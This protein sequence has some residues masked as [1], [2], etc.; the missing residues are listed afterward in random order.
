MNELD[1]KRW[2]SVKIHSTLVV[3]ECAAE[4]IQPIAKSRKLLYYTLIHLQYPFSLQ[5]MFLS[6]HFFLSRNDYMLTIR[7]IIP[8][9]FLSRL[10]SQIN[11]LLGDRPPK[12]TVTIHSFYSYSEFRSDC[13]DF[14][15]KN[16]QSWFKLTV[17]CPLK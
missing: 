12:L 6:I 10:A 4:L 11:S 9:R 1:A 15:L 14:V 13:S 16:C 17:F 7:C 5:S 3:Q 2:K 8:S